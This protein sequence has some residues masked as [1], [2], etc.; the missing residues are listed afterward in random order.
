[1]SDAERSIKHYYVSSPVATHAVLLLGVCNSHPVLSVS[2]IPSCVFTAD[3]LAFCSAPPPEEEDDELLQKAFVRAY[4]QDF[5]KDGIHEYLPQIWR[6]FCQ[7]ACVVRDG[8]GAS[9]V[10]QSIAHRLHCGGMTI[11]IEEYVKECKHSDYIQNTLE[12]FLWRCS[13]SQAANDD[14]GDSVSKH[15][16]NGKIKV[17]LSEVPDV[18]AQLC[19]QKDHLPK[20]TE[21][22]KA[23]TDTSFT[24][25]INV[26]GNPLAPKCTTTSHALHLAYDGTSQWFDKVR[27]LV[28]EAHKSI[29]AEFEGS[30]WEDALS[31]AE[32]MVSE[33]GYSAI[34]IG[35][36][37]TPSTVL[38]CA[39]VPSD[40]SNKKFTELLGKRFRA[41]LDVFRPNVFREYEHLSWVYASML[42]GLL[43]SA[44]GRLIATFVD[45]VVKEQIAQRAPT[46]PHLSELLG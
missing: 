41:V 33:V 37:C 11:D 4:Y 30:T 17:V 3:V 20:S 36:K 7:G 18:V 2:P 12:N 1:M 24:S 21:L 38:Y 28:K 25:V 29:D 10:D 40:F 13:F 43:D 34:T 19:D 23:R 15:D 27:V 39:S 35:R 9:H 45:D 42:N 32:D 14:C 8:C 44:D 31:H 22:H 16:T 26:R 5:K 6:I 46:N